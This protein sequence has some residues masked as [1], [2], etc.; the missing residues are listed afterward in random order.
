MPGVPFP[1]LWVCGDLTWLQKIQV[2]RGQVK[3]P[4]LPVC[5]ASVALLSQLTHRSRAH[6]VRAFLWDFPEIIERMLV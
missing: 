6:G 2:S 1:L 4:L 5:G 3:Q